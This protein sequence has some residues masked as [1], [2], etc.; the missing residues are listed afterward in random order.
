[1][2]D[3]EK[4][5]YDSFIMNGFKIIRVEIEKSKFICEDDDYNNYIRV[6]YNSFSGD[7]FFGFIESNIMENAN[8]KEG[9][10]IRSALISYRRK[11]KLSK[12]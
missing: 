3:L 4:Y 6:I 10:I 11:N 9:R 2:T 1:M 8:S 7:K 5:I 12:I